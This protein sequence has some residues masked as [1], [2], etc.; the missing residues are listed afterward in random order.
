MSAAN[1]KLQEP[2]MEEILASIRR[3]IADDQEAPKPAPAPAPAPKSVP[4][5][6][7][8]TPPPPG[9]K[10]R[11][12]GAFRA[13]PAAGACAARGRGRARAWRGRPAG[14]ARD[15]ADPAL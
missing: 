1:P 12:P 10:S 8:A 7:F 4:P 11:P 9:P 3:I 14:A 2:S 5:A 6:A 13:P 15:P